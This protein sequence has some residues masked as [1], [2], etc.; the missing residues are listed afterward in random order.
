MSIIED[1]EI[2]GVRIGK[3]IVCFICITDEED[4]EIEEKDFITTEEIENTNKKW[5]CAR[6]GIRL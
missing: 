3:E 5:F 6:C 1:E 2:R 4:T